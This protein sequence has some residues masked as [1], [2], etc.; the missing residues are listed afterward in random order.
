MLVAQ[1]CPTLQPQGVKPSRFL[2]PW[3][4]PGKNTGMG[5]HSLL[6]GIFSPQELN[7]SLLHCRLILYHLSHQGSFKW[8]MNLLYSSNTYYALM[9]IV[10]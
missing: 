1:L 8:N 3:N 9:L 7:L 2:C 6:R 4:S 5:C 10:I